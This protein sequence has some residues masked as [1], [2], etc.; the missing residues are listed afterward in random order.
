ME[1]PLEPVSSVAIYEGGAD[2]AANGDVVVEDGACNHVWS[3]E[4]DPSV[5]GI[6]QAVDGAGNG[7]GDGQAD[8]A[9]C[10]VNQKFRVQNKASTDWTK[11]CRLVTDRDASNACDEEAAAWPGTGC[12]RHQTGLRRT[13]RQP[14]WCP[15]LPRRSQEGLP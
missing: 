4:P 15:L 11:R 7:D 1:F 9:Q 3:V 14:A 8:S 13:G 12:W 2:A 10:T 6:L 5:A